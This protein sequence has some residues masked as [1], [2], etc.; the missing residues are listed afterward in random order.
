MTADVRNV[1]D[2]YL[3]AALLSCG[4]K[5]LGVDR[6]DK[7]RQRFKFEGLVPNAVI[8]DDDIKLVNLKNIRIEEFEVYYISG[9]MWFPP[10]Y[11]ASVKQIKS[12]IHSG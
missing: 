4:V 1:S 6:Q 11:P 8:A 9:R 7:S 3:A 5:F 12:A 10:S 2:M